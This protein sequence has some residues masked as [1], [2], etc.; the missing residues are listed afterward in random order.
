MSFSKSVKEELL[1]I[2]PQ[3]L[4]C[5]IAEIAAI[6]NMCGQVCMDRRLKVRTENLMVAEKYFHLIQAAF[7]IRCEVRISRHIPRQKSCIYEV[8][9]CDP[10]QSVRVLKA[11]KLLD[12]AGDAGEEDSPRQNLIIQNTCCK[13]AYLRGVFLTGGSITD[14]NKSYHLEITTQT[15]PKAKQLCE[16][17]QVFD[18]EARIIKRK[19]VYVVYIK[20]SSHIADFLN[21]CGAHTALMDLENVRIVKEMRNSINRQVNCETANIGKTVRASVRQADDI[22]YI[23]DKRGFASLPDN[24]AEMARLRLEY[25]EASL[26]ELGDRTNP[27]IGKSGV[28]HRLRRLSEIAGQI[29]DQENR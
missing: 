8:L 20:D 25:P 2:M 19:R 16:M 4:H 24:L 26:K 27:P 13:R 14:P 12:A 6:V 22:C 1:Q 23:R 15:L 21:V 28:N 5:R 17:I 18:I 11:V 9:L 7:S 29:R 10:E 3:A